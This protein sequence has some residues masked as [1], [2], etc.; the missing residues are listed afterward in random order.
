MMNT[1]SVSFRRAFSL[2]ELLVVVSIF[3]FISVVILANHSKFNTN[4]LLDSLAYNS[5]LSVRQAQVYGISVR[6]SAALPGEFQIGYGVHFQKSTPSQYILFAD[7]NKNKKYD[8]TP[9]DSIVETYVIGRGH[10]IKQFCA[11]TTTTPNCSDDASAPI[12]YLDITFLRP[13]PDASFTTDKTGITYSRATF[14]LAS[15]GDTTRTVSVA[16]TGEVSVTGADA[17]SCTPSNICYLGNVVNSCTGAAV[18]NCQGNGCT[19]G[20]CNACVPTNICSGS[21]VVNS[22]TGAVV[23]T[24]QYGCSGGSC[25]GCTPNGTYSCS[26][27]NRIDSCSA[28]VEACTYGCSGGVCNTCTPTYSCDNGYQ[29]INSCTGGVAKTC[30]YQCGGAYPT[31]VI[32]DGCF[33]PETPVLMADGSAKAIRDVHVGDSVLGENTDGSRVANTVTWVFVHNGSYKVLRVNGSLLV[34]PVHLMKTLR[35]WVAAG[36]LVVGDILVGAE[37]VVPVLSVEESGTLPT[38]Y[39]LTTVPSHTYFAGGILVHN[40]KN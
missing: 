5:A 39:N 28:V 1:R 23:Q 34:T 29:W 12:N 2:I 21:N 9:T 31:C 7:L 16:T 26:G 32:D 25:S 22:C 6:Q 33:S 17:T 3:S 11:H 10:H 20:A 13:V 35:G 40:V 36:D 38:V 27:S 15:A 24:C 19:G 30:A 4:V 14:T 8:G 18:T 37:G